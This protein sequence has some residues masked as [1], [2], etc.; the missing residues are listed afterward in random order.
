MN[1]KKITLAFWLLQLIGCP[2]SLL[3]GQGPDWHTTGNTISLNQNIFGTLNNSPV[4]VI[5]NNQWSGILDPNGRTFM[6]YHTGNSTAPASNV[7]FGY[8]V[9][10]VNLAMGNTG[11]GYRV[12]RVNTTG[13]YNTGF[14]DSALSANVSGSGNT[15]IGAFSLQS[16]DIGDGNTAVG[17]AALAG[18]Y[19]G[20][21]NTATG[22]GALQFNYS[23]NEN[24]AFGAGSLGNNLDGS[25][26]TA[27]GTSS[28]YGNMSGNFGTA[29]GHEAMYM[30]IYG[31]Y[32]V[33]IGA[34]ALHENTVG[35]N[36]VA[37]GDSA[38]YLNGWGV[39]LPGLDASSNTGVG[40]SALRWNTIGKNNTALGS[41]ALRM[42]GTGHGNTACGAFSL[43][44]TTTGA[45]NTG[46]GRD[47]LLHN[48]VG[49][50]NIA[51]GSA[52]LLRNTKGNLN[53]AAGYQSLQANT[54]GIQNTAL[55]AN[56]NTNAGNRTNAM[57]LGYGA[58]VNANNKTRI[59]NT[60]MTVVETQT[61][62]FVT[63]D[64][65]FKTNVQEEVAG[66][67]FI[68]RLRPVVYNFDTRKF[69]E[70]LTHNMPDSMRAQYLDGADFVASTAIRQSGFLAQE[71]EEAM[72]ATGYDF[73]GLHR[74]NDADDNYSLAYSQFVVPLVKAAQELKEL[75]DARQEEILALSAEVK[76]LKA[77]VE[78][79][80][81]LQN[82]DQDFPENRLD[83]NIPNPFQEKTII[84]FAVSV[85]YPETYISINSFEG[86][87]VA[88]FPIL[89]AGE[90][91]V[92]VA[93]NLLPAGTYI[94]TLVVNGNRVASHSMVLMR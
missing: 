19:L 18:N 89:K 52:A 64:A 42:N 7:G 71:V 11:L 80:A 2:L 57:A 73:N 77:M 79:C 53:T 63:S 51:L 4:H 39:N 5:L 23:G 38:L 75:N 88:R 3:F 47:A 69:T 15:A 82:H 59:G 9:L 10:P 27:F 46:V 76:T 36:L 37:V 91:E 85:V 33:A 13:D 48:D 72:H 74:P 55:G 31:S 81:T 22:V 65:R 84:R 35:S 70:F 17:G 40:S 29:L 87:E 49:A 45:N 78:R 26:N 1:Q 43:S 32:N 24:A 66:L 28:M 41:R 8:E 93:G 25:S 61:N 58:I 16:N 50:N 68:T 56:A 20:D 90:G 34:A 92:A 83:R 67:E 14:G 12:L 44:Q 86:M 60:Q 62:T 21:A 94:Y 54:I 6:G 30:N